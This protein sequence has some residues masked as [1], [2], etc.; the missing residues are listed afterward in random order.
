MI[1]INCII[2]WGNFSINI[3]PIIE[4]LIRIDVLPHGRS[5]IAFSLQQIRP[6]TPRDG[7]RNLLFGLCGSVYTNYIVL[8]HAIM[9]TPSCVTAR[10]LRL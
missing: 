2:V 5:T 1:A 3:K 8:C 9:R 6:S 4:Y 7:N 10:V